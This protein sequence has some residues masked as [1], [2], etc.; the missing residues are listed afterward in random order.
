MGRP[1]TYD[2]DEVTDRAMRLFWERGYHATSI[3]DLT[4]VMGVNAYSLYAEFGSKEQLYDQA[5]ERYHQLVVTQHFGRLEAHDASLDEVEA[6]L[7]FFGGG[8]EVRASTLG[9]LACNAAVELA[10][11]TETSRV[12]TDRYMERVSR[13]FRHALRNAQAEG[14]LT[15]APVDELAEFLTVTVTGMLVLIRAGCHH[16]YL[17][18]TARQAIERL[19]QFVVP[20]VAP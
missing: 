6:V 5:M 16:E 15:G 20:A 1:K 19:H 12:S 17:G 9:C 11:T 13:A 14:Q 8:P 4:D 10:P 3:R 2:R 18:S 7:R